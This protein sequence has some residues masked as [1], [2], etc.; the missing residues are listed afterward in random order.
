VSAV[1]QKSGESGDA[2]IYSKSEVEGE[3]NDDYWG[4]RAGDLCRSE[5]LY[6]EEEDENGA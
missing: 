4:E 1:V 5:G 3:P 2:Y 6:E